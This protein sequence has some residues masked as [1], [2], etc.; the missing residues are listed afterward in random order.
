[1]RT[2]CT[3]KRPGEFCIDVGI[4]RIYVS[5]ENGRMPTGHTRVI[6]TMSFETI[7]HIALASRTLIGERF[8]TYDE[9]QVLLALHDLRDTADRAGSLRRACRMTRCLLSSPCVRCASIKLAGS[10]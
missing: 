9:A 1:V 8:P 5:E 6:D 7:V 4:N 3:N 2:P 10:P